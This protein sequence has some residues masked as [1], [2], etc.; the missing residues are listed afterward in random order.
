MRNGAHAETVLMRGLLLKESLADPGVL[1]LLHITQTEQW[2]VSNP[3]ADQPPVWTALSFD[4]PV[5]QDDRIAEALSQAL[6]QRGWFI[7]ATSGETVY[8]IFPGRVFRYL[9]GDASEGEAA[10]SYGISLGIPARQLDWDD[11]REED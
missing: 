8:V 5:V 6:K 9:N 4:C 2:Q 3:S 1:D 11:G 10:R 7:D